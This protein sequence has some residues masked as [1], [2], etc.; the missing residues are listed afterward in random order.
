M[1]RVLEPRRTTSGYSRYVCIHGHFYQPPRDDPRTGKVEAQPSAHPYHDW[2]ERVTAECYTPNA[3]ARVLDRR[4]R[5]AEVRNNYAQISLNFG[6][7]LLRWME[8]QAPETYRALLDADLR[9]RHRFGDHGS[10]LAQAHGH[11]ILPLANRRD[12]V[13]EVRWGLADF[14]HRFGRPAEGMWLPEAAVDTETLEVLAEEGVG[15]TILAPE[16]AARVRPPEGEEGWQDVSGGQVNPRRPYRCRLPSGGA[17]T[18]FFYD[19]PLSRAVAFEGLLEDGARLARR[20]TSAFDPEQGDP[21]IVHIAT[22]GESYGHH[23]RH[24]EMA[25]AYALR[26]LEAQEDV[27]LINHGRFLELH[28]PTWEAEIVEPSSWSCPHGVERWRSDCGCFTG[29]EPHWNQGWRA[30]L[31]QALDFLRDELGERFEQAGGRMFRDPWEARNDYIHV[32]LDDSPEVR[33]AFLAR[34]ARQGVLERPEERSRGWKLLEMQ[35]Y[36]LSMLTSCGWFFNDVAGIETVQVLRYAAQTV[37][38][39]RELF[40]IDLEEPF[41]AILQRAESNRPEKG[42]GRRIWEA[43]IRQRRPAQAQ[44]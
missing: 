44:T 30:P 34:H 28:P 2:N 39:A 35:R 36:A 31:R 38:L 23:H 17:I 42:T 22:D 24:G 11:L 33:N 19:G 20:L 29:G 40:E 8:R 1:S 5:V 14:E 18:L 12:K 27:E 3:F 15:F 7:T 41:L 37:D 13:T 21:Q 6:P 16:Q 10:G 25:L 4:G 32:L 9:S 26:L 43:E